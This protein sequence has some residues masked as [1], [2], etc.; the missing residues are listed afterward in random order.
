MRSMSFALP[1]VILL[2]AS[3]LPAIE[4]VGQQPAVLSG[5]RHPLG[6]G[7]IDDGSAQL[8]GRGHGRG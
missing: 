1:A 2:G 6:H 5:E 4:A 8:R 3:L 7:L